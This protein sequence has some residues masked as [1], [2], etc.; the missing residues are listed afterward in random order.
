[1]KTVHPFLKVSAI[2]L[3]LAAIG[4]LSACFFI[5]ES[6]RP[7]MVELAAISTAEINSFNWAGVC[8]LILFL[9]Y[10][11]FLLTLTKS[12]QRV[13]G[14]QPVHYL[15]VGSGV[16]ALVLVFADF[17]LLSDIVKQFKH[18]LTQ[19]EWS[20]VYPIITFQWLSVIAGLWYLFT[21]SQKIKTANKIKV[22]NNILLALHFTGVLCGLMGF[23]LIGLGFFNPR[24]WSLPVHTLL[25]SAILLSPYV[26]M[27][28]LWLYHKLRDEK[29]PFLDEKQSQDI[30]HSALLTLIACTILLIIVYF[31]NLTNLAGILS[32]LWLPFYLFSAL[33][34][35]SIVNL[36]QTERPMD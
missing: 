30:S 18:G 13:E 35:F 9:F 36:L 4:L 10:C 21:G 22:D 33:F 16:V 32:Q 12:L 1:M 15:M 8:L 26:L 27:M 2:V 17:A 25:S 19:P 31:A 29:S 6:L 24:G 5:F 3:G 11:S 7:R 34:I 14:I 28:G 23:G 20:L